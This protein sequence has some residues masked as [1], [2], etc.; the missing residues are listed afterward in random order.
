MDPQTVQQSSGRPGFWQSAN[1][2]PDDFRNL[3]KAEWPG[4]ADHLPRRGTLRRERIINL[5]CDRYGISSDEAEQQMVA[6]ERIYR[7]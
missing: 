2:Y 3:L 1:Q 5:I 4:V 7:G 6:F